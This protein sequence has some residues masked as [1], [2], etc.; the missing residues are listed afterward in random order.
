MV[1]FTPF[2]PANLYS[3]RKI[4]LLHSHPLSCD[5]IITLSIVFIIMT[6]LTYRG[7]TGKSSIEP[8]TMTTVVD[9]SN[10]KPSDTPS[11]W[12]S[13]LDPV[14]L[15]TLPHYLPIIF[16]AGCSTPANEKY[17]G[18]YEAYTATILI[19]STLS[20]IWHSHHE[21]KNIWFWLDY[22]FAFIWTVFD[23]VL[24][25]LKAPLPSILT[26]FLLNGFVLITNQMG[27]Y[28]DRK[29]LVP[30][31]Q[32]HSLWHIFSWVKATF[33]AYLVGCRYRSTCEGT[34]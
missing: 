28:L 18:I 11:K 29:G 22:L 30:Y 7:S 4:K 20:I 6:S 2:A 24:A 31:Q 8:T 26:V 10:N 5:I 17:P 14:I 16:V 32:A 19:S 34:Y 12:R 33:V 3:N 15:S 9:Y 23:F 1:A 13:F 25:I 21:R 27:D